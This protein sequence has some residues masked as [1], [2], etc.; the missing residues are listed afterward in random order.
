ME[1]G[2]AIDVSVSKL[3]AVRLT[4]FVL[5][6]ALAATLLAG[7]GASTNNS[8]EDFKGDQKSVAQVV[9][10]LG[11]AVKKR[12]AKEICNTIFA[13][14][15]ADKLKQGNTDCVAAVKNQVKDASSFDVSVK[16]VAISGTNATAVVTST[17]DGKDATQTLKLVKDG[18]AWR[19]ASLQSP[20]AG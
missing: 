5:P 17:V 15:V 3:R 11:K 19:I 18:N 20:A 2:R 9:D 10:D 4:A 1:T 16:K 7:C 13:T 14:S 8:A 6:A 12:D